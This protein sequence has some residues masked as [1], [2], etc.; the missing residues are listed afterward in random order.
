MGHACF[1]VALA[2]GFSAYL[3]LA[4][5]TGHV[6]DFRHVA[7]G[8]AAFLGFAFLWLG[9]VGFS[10][11][12]F[13]IRRFIS[14]TLDQGVFAFAMYYSG[15]VLAPVMW[16]PV[17][18]A[19]GNGLRNGPQF[20]KLSAVL[21]AFFATIALWSSPYWN[22]SHL[23]FE[24]I[25]ASILILPWYTMALS[26]QIARA[27]REMQKRAAIFESASRT[28][29]LTEVLN[30]SGFFHALEQALDRVK[31]KGIP[32]AVML[33]DLDGFKAVNDA[34]GHGTGDNVLKEVAARLRSSFRSGDKIARI[35]GD[36]FG[37]VLNDV[38]NYEI[39]ERL[40][41]KIIDAIAEIQVPNR[42]DLRLGASIGICALSKEGGC[43]DSGEIMDIADRLMYQSKRAGKNQF[44]I[45]SAFSPLLH[46]AA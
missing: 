7:V 13:K 30:R 42:P 20:A 9:V 43:D 36:E 45:A 19:I 17:L 8:L 22:T 10:L 26:D 12:T 34:C 27:K 1:R 11:L 37:I 14:I 4:Y 3:L 23:L 28:D 44:R 33:L 5:V 2:L 21:G 35:G 41:Q 40:A 31:D 39:V 16:G 6:S 29:S 15:D 46:A 38:Q 32:A 25:V 18:M 24:G